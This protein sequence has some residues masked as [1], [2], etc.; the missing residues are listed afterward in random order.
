MARILVA[1][2]LAEAGVRLLRSS[3]HE[4][5]E[6]PSIT[7]EELLAAVAEADA[8]VVRSATRVDAEVL[9][10]GVPRLKV[11]GRAG[12]GLD[13]VDV[14]AAT[15]LGVMVVNAPQSNVI[16]A[17]EHTIALI[18]AQARNIPQAHA[19]LRQGRWERQRFQGTELHGKTL[20]IVGLG[21]VGT[22]V[23]HRLLAFGMRLCA[24]DP[25]VSRERAAQLGVELVSLEEVL[26]RADVLTIHLP[27]TP[28]T[29]GLIGDRELR[30]MKPGARLVNTARGGIVDEA[31][32][33]K[34][35]ADGHLA[36]AALDVFSEEPCTHSP[37]FEVDRVVVTPH[38]G[39]ST[40]EAQDK[41]GITIAEQL[42]LALSGQLVPNAVNVE[43]GPVP[44]EL[45]PFLPLAE[46]LGRIYTALT[47]G[48]GAAGAG[49]GWGG[50]V[51]VGYV[52]ELA[53]SDCRVLTLAALRG[54]LAPVVQQ[55][56]TYVNVP[57]LAA[58]RGLEV[59]ET[60]SRQSRDWVNVITIAGEGPR[61]PVSV[62]GTTV[63]PRDAERLVAINGIDLD[64]APAEHMALLFYED[65][66]GVIGKVGTILGQADVNI[67]SMQV[68]RRRAGG[69]ALMALTVDAAIP[70]GVLERVV[71]E[72]GAHDGV[73][74]HLHETGA[75]GA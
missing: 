45:R 69:E 18:L 65:R 52:G 70:P 16:S 38:L 53:S 37:L 32:L 64:L 9:Q 40:H 27:K 72:I 55:P 28:E 71:E 60:R 4:V 21:R 34:A 10:A 15:R 5:D 50:Q 3:G 48:R 57:L 54:M 20:G 41:A 35:V 1:E 24:Y 43:A 8:L 49:A 22:L 31:A 19:A 26:R 67:A 59:T 63:G 30:L 75:A 29:V 12:I 33:A 47:S 44:D 17:A 13:N 2:P 62:A 36:G 23:A 73:F 61:G 25:Y 46:K 11:V 66:P 68:G 56:V 74:L 7:R 6:R 58:E 39:A 14:P 42:I 51:R